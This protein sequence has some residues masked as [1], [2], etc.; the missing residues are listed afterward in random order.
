MSA[1]DDLSPQLS[2]Y[3]DAIRAARARSGLT[4]EELA[5]RSGVPYST[6]CKVQSGLQNVTIPQAAALCATLGIT[7]DDIVRLSDVPP[8]GS[9]GELTQ[10]IHDLQLE[11]ADRAGD[12]RVLQ[13]QVEILTAQLHSYRHVLFSLLGLCVLL[14][15][16]L[17][18]YLIMDANI[19]NAGFIIGGDFT[20]GAWVAVLMLCAGAYVMGRAW[21]RMSTRYAARAAAGPDTSREEMAALL[22]PLQPRPVRR[23]GHISKEG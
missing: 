18:V 12:L 19:P 6:I 10:Q 23:D 8:S 17:V 20:F 14:S 22:R 1:L 21:L 3:P 7:L 9:D 16:S 2:A 5:E 11:R 13:M 15:L 4:N